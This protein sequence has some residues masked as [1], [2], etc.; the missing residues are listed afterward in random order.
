MTGKLRCHMCMF[1]L[2]C[3]LFLPIR[4]VCL[5][6]RL[7]RAFDG[8]IDAVSR[9]QNFL[10][11]R[12]TLRASWSVVLL[13]CAGTVGTCSVKRADLV[14][15]YKATAHLFQTIVFRLLFCAVMEQLLYLYSYSLSEASYQPPFFTVVRRGGYDG[16]DGMRFPKVQC[17]C[18]LFPPPPPFFVVRSPLFFNPCKYQIALLLHSSFSSTCY[19]PVLLIT[20]TAT[21][22]VTA[23]AS[24]C[25]G[26]NVGVNGPLM[27]P[28]RIISPSSIT[29]SNSSS[30][31]R[32]CKISIIDLT[33]DIHRTTI[34]VVFSSSQH[35]CSLSIHGRSARARFDKG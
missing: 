9:L 23:Q 29:M 18:M 8:A 34:R 19:E 6:A 14:C 31:G 28:S 24:L 33:T 27:Q 3:R 16:M 32:S 30:T 26:K 7:E 4:R 21:E 1:M 35:G 22:E 17:R 10:S 2:S 13:I 25:E 11:L 15:I 5:H 20:T 12:A